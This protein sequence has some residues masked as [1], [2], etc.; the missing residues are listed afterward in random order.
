METTPSPIMYS[1]RTEETSWDPAV[2]DD[3]R[4]HLERV[5]RPWTDKYGSVKDSQQI[6]KEDCPELIRWMAELAAHRDRCAVREDV[7]FYKG[8]L[9][10]PRLIP[11]GSLKV[12]HILI[13]KYVFKNN[14]F[15]SLGASGR[16]RLPMIPTRALKIISQGCQN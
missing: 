9:R 12:R 8:C 1:L 10:T 2:Q 14:F 6:K 13:T 16:V 15:L 3:L 7:I 11:L 4:S 5:Y